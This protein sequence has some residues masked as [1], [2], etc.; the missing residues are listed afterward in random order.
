MCSEQRSLTPEPQSLWFFSFHNNKY[1]LLSLMYPS[2]VWGLPLLTTLGIKREVLRKHGTCNSLSKVSQQETSASTSQPMPGSAQLLET[3]YFGSFHILWYFPLENTTFISLDCIQDFSAQKSIGCSF[4]KYHGLKRLQ[5]VRA[6]SSRAFAHESTPV[7]PKRIC[8]KVFQVL[9]LS[10]SV[11]S[12]DCIKT[13]MGICIFSFLMSDH[14]ITGY[15]FT[16]H[17]HNKTLA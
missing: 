8:K 14:K 9:S 3:S 4:R 12:G 15:L 17:H 11:C 7:G 16:C 13:S 5:G 6:Q 10:L 2:V 1:I